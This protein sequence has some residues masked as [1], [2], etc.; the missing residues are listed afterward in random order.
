[1]RSFH[2]YRRSNTRVA[3]WIGPALVAAGAALLLAACGGSTQGSAGSSGSSSASTTPT[4][5]T[6][7]APAT[8]PT[9]S[10]QSAAVMTATATVKGQSETVLVNGKGMTLYYYTPD[11]DKSVTCTGGCAA[12][13]PPLVAGSSTPSSIAGVSGMFGSDPDPAGGSVITYNGWPLYTFAS[14]TA[15]GQTNGQG[16]QGVWFVATPSLAANATGTTS[17][18]SSTTGGSGSSATATPAPKSGGSSWS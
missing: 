2:Y 9:P 10:V 8:T 7:S 17:S 5:A 4:P 14:D 1:M 12:V 13:W 3:A 15:P 16:V 18:S 11:K 6:T